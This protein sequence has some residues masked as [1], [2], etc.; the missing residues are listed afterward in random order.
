MDFETVCRDFKACHTSQNVYKNLTS[1]EDGED[2]II[3]KVFNQFLIQ[4]RQTEKG[5]SFQI[6]KTKLRRL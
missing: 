2:S 6:K 3:Q 4:T 5:V 1:S